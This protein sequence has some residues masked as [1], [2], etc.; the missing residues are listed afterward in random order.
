MKRETV[1]AA[2]QIWAFA[3]IFL[4]LSTSSG[5]AQPGS[6]EIHHQQAVVEPRTALLMG[7]SFFAPV[8]TNVV[9]KHHKA[10]GIN[11]E[12]SK[13][14]FVSNKGGHPYSLW[15][16][17]GNGSKIKRILDQGKTEILG[18]TYFPSKR[19]GDNLDSVIGYENWVAYAIDAGNPLKKVFIAVPWPIGP[20]EKTFKQRSGPI[21][22]AGTKTIHGFIDTLRKKFATIEFVVSPYGL[23]ALELER[24]L[25]NGKLNGEITDFVGPESKSIYKDPRGHAGPMLITLSE[26]I[27]LKAVFGVDL[28][29]YNFQHGYA[30][31]LNQIATEIVE[32]YATAY[33]GYIHLPSG[34]DSASPS[35]TGTG[36]TSTGF[37]R[38]NEEM[39]PTERQLCGPYPPGKHGW[40]V[41]YDALRAA[42]ALTVLGFF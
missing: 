39:Q 30:T 12:T 37:Q 24:R 4:V 40:L 18:M 27:W 15:K 22:T 20:R 7:H 9:N 23:G 28:R 32:D 41:V 13:I 25:T 42:G 11:S 3:G 16:H 36:G 21:A 29:K 31:D 26:L 19:K 1:K 2:L 17:R 5:F 38:L 35:Q 6:N 10:A 8:A 34:D 33:P 14:V